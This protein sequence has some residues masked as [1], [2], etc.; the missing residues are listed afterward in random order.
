MH[1][2]SHSTAYSQSLPSKIGKGQGLTLALCPGQTKKHMRHA[3]LVKSEVTET[4]YL[5]FP[6]Q[7]VK[8]YL[9]K[10][11]TSSESDLKLRMLV[12]F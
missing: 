7:S 4:A 8:M 11:S 2:N 1:E 6:V 9:M 12:W 10:A 5:G 3:N